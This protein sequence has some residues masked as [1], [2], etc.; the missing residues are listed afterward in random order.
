[1]FR[2][3]AA[4]T[5]LALLAAAPSVQAHRLEA[6]ATVRP[7]GIVQVES[8]F[9]TG[10]VPKAAAVEVFRGGGERLMGGKTDDQGMFIF[11]YA[12]A[13]PLRVVVNA[14]AGHRAEVQVKRTDLER[15]A[16]ATRA[17]QT[18]LAGMMPEPSPYLAA[19]LLVE[20]RSEGTPAL[21]P[22]SPTAERQTGPQFGRLALGVGSLLLVAGGAVL[23]RRLRQ[24][25]R[26][27]NR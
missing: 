26:N 25:G 4:V 16:V 11:A 21:P 9:E 5:F 18:W 3:S 6:E 7:F 14:G 1:M 10:D 8:W 17:L 12:D 13:E 22:A 27:Q 20:V 24:G 15:N 23:L 19:A 2:R